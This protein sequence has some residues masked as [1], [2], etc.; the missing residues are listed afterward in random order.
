MFIN[1]IVDYD[2]DGILYLRVEKCLLT[3]LLT[4]MWMISYISGLRMFINL[5]VDY[6]VDGILY[7]RVENVY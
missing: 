4:T 7:L 3:W 1:L 5:I 6:D 2:V